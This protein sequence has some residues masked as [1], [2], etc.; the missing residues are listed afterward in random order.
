[1]SKR[2]NCNRY[3]SKPPRRNIIKTLFIKTTNSETTF[4]H[5]IKGTY[6]IKKHL[7]LECGHVSEY[8][9]V[10][11]GQKTV[12]CFQCQSIHRRNRPSL[13][14][15][16]NLKSWSD[17]KVTMRLCFDCG[18]ELLDINDFYYLNTYVHCEKCFTKKNE[19]IQKR[20]NSM[21]FADE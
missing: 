17:P 13:L 15:L 6:E 19:E 3:V 21:E 8:R 20:L 12:L 7:L 4:K 1:M 14:E 11:A 18:V 2:V 16:E 5:S 10:R 9:D